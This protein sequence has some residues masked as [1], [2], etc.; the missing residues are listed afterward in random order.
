MG[1]LFS[2]LFTSIWGLLL[3]KIVGV[4]YTYGQVYKI[5]MLIF[6]LFLLIDLINIY[7]KL[8]YSF[9]V[10]IFTY[11]IITILVFYHTKNTPQK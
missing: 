5:G 11:T 4:K 9:F 10:G 3:S 2:H 6:P 1:N 8:T 7:T